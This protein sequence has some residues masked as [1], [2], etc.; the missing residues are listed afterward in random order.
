[1]LILY[2]VLL[3]SI[4]ER[5]SHM[6]H[7]SL[8]SSRGEDDDEESNIDYAVRK[9]KESLQVQGKVLKINPIV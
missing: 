8:F 4:L 3:V 5:Q 9:Y 7:V 2:A 1:M 6:Y